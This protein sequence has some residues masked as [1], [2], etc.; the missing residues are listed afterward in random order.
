MAK[1]FRRFRYEPHL[2]KHSSQYR[3]THNINS[4]HYIESHDEVVVLSE[5]SGAVN[6][7]DADACVRKRSFS[8]PRGAPMSAEYVDEYEAMIMSF[9][10]M[11]MEMWD[12][13]PGEDQYTVMSDE[14]GVSR[15]WPTS[16]AQLSLRWLARHRKLYAGSSDGVVQAWNVDNMKVTSDMRGHS[17]VV[18]DLHHLKGVDTIASASLDKTICIWD[19]YTSSCQ[20]VLSGHRLGVVSLTYCPNQRILM[21]AGFDHDVLVWSPFSNAVLS[22]LKGHRNSIVKVCRV[23]DDSSNEVMTADVS[24]VFK[25]WDVRNFKCIQTFESDGE[26]DVGRLVAFSAIPGRRKD[27]RSRTFDLDRDASANVRTARVF[28]ASRSFLHVFERDAAPGAGVMSLADD[29]PVSSMLFYERRSWLITVHS[30]TIKIWDASSGTL[31]REYRNITTGV[32]TAVCLTSCGENVVLGEDSGRV[33]VYDLITGK[34]RKIL[35]P[36]KSEIVS[37]SSDAERR[38]I[39]TTDWKG[40]NVI[41]D[42]RTDV[43]GADAVLLCMDPKRM[44]NHSDDVTTATLSHDLLATGGADGTVH[45]WNATDGKIESI[46]KHGPDRLRCGRRRGPDRERDERLTRR[47]TTCV[48]FMTPQ[49]LLVACE[50]TGF[51]E[52]WRLSR[53]GHKCERVLRSNLLSANRNIPVCTIHC[54]WD[55]D[56]SRLY[57]G[58]DDGSVSCVCVAEILRRVREDRTQGTTP[59]R[60]EADVSVRWTRRGVHSNCI[61]GMVL[62]DAAIPKRL[63]SSSFDCTVVLWDVESGDA[64]ASLRQGKPDP[65]WTLSVRSSQIDGSS[66]WMQTSSSEANRVDA[67]ARPFDPLRGP[68]CEDDMKTTFPK[69]TSKRRNSRQV[70]KK[71]ISIDR[72]EPL[73]MSLPELRTTAAKMADESA[74]DSSFTLK[75]LFQRAIWNSMRNDR[76]DDMKTIENEAR[77]AGLPSIARLAKRLHTQGTQYALV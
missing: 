21:S 22:K 34:V 74:E 66:L 71:R 69:I 77:R 41:H 63:A 26:P 32:V 62:L 1:D 20:Q 51:V 28:A 36:H 44:R 12:F 52:I 14:D 58:N 17:D 4:T 15:C 56:A 6:V 75:Q 37:I 57:V 42:D 76:I 29:E 18:A 13:A 5:R 67:D 43:G 40:N 30:R 65:A 10:D 35:F 54:V 72:A 23:G 59:E 45:L 61:S 47:Y 46:L 31:M 27:H 64:I 19:L 11:T 39:V 55:H 24:G 50:S 7:Y 49:P 38:T 68:E 3:H 60:T 33:A 9:G 53:S 8:L 16:K 48:R 25:I 70:S 73:T 2:S